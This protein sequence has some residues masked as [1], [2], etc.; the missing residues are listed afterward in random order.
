MKFWGQIPEKLEARK[1]EKMGENDQIAKTKG[2]GGKIRIAEEKARE[3][4]GKREKI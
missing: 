3:E 2:G 4:S 1:G